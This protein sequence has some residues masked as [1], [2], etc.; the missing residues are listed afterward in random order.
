M[1][2]RTTYIILFRGVG[3]ATSLPVQP[4]KAALLADGF[5]KVVTYI[6]TGNV[7]LVS[8]RTPKQIVADS[9]R[10]FAISARQP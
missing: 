4:L 6:T 9:H 7:V 5:E 2:R 3:G 10:A 8:D 1:G